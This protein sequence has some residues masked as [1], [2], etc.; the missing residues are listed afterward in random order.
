MKYISVLLSFFVI[1]LFLGC[2]TKITKNIE[3]VNLK[4]CL[5]K[6]NYQNN[7]NSINNGPRVINDIKFIFDNTDNEIVECYLDELG[8]SKRTN[9]I[10]A[11][12]RIHDFITIYQDY[13]YDSINNDEGVKSITKYIYDG[14]GDCEDKAM[15]SFTLMKAI[16]IEPYIIDVDKVNNGIGHVALGLTDEVF[17][18]DK[19]LNRFV[20]KWK[21]K[22]TKKSMDLILFDPSDGK[23]MS[24]QIGTGIIYNKYKEEKDKYIFYIERI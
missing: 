15:F 7:E 16:N 20:L 22:V 6:F 12:K 4:N 18:N 19:K 14:G 10:E 8:I 17:I 23:K 24:K 2:E 21:S 13:Q 5:V 3:E 1:L 9:K 11:I